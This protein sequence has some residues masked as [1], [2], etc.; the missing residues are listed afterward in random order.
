MSRLSG[1][2]Q[3]IQ[4]GDREEASSREREIGDTPRFSIVDREDE[5]HP[6]LAP[7]TATVAHPARAGGCSFWGLRRPDATADSC[8]GLL[9]SR[10]AH[11]T[12]RRPSGPAPSG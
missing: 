6:G 10:D 2:E 5:I 11:Q 4:S 1:G 12:L 9:H 7:A 3:W 8:R